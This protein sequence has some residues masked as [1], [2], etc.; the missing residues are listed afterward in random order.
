MDA[1]HRVAVPCK[2]IPNF[3]DK[4][5]II[6]IYYPIWDR[7]RRLLGTIA[8]TKIRAPLPRNG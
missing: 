6:S 3:A 8:Q 7:A 1:I 2:V 5:P 4:S